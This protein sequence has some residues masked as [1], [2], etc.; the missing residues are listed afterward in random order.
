MEKKILVAIYESEFKTV[1]ELNPEIKEVDSPNVRAYLGLT[2][3]KSRKTIAS[4]LK[5]KIKDMTEEEQEKLLES[6]QKKKK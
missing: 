6:L 5:D 3:V 2:P 4:I 1:L